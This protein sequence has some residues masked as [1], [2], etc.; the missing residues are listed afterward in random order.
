MAHF[1]L[2]RYTLVPVTSK[3]ESELKLPPW[4]HSVG[5]YITWFSSSFRV[6]CAETSLCIISETKTKYYDNLHIFG[7]KEQI[8]YYFYFRVKNTKVRILGGVGGELGHISRRRYM[9]V[10]LW[11]TAS[12]LHPNDTHE[13]M[14]PRLQ[15]QRADVSK[16]GASRQTEPESCC[17]TP[18]ITI[19]IIIT[20]RQHGIQ[21]RCWQE[22]NIRRWARILYSCRE[23]SCSVL[24]EW[25]Q[26]AHV[27][28]R[29]INLLIWTFQQFVHNKILSSWL[30][31]WQMA[32][33]HLI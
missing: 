18:L 25:K 10:G 20:E 22:T 19:Q 17:S 31:Q 13:Q 5:V 16:K 7:H 28:Y 21:D 23:K 29:E 32:G 12:K 27:H 14:S 26:C 3:L 2:Q 15:T 30:S 33:I 8:S 9:Y 11:V 6:N 24:C 1:G 4:W